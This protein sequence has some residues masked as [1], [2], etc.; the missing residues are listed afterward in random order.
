MGLTLLAAGCSSGPANSP[1][2]SSSHAVPAVHT[3]P[4]SFTQQ[5]LISG[6]DLTVQGALTTHG[7]LAGVHANGAVALRGQTSRVAG[8]LTSARQVEAPAG[9]ARKRQNNTPLA[10]ART[11]RP[12]LPTI[13]TLLQGGTPTGGTPTHA[14]L[15]GSDGAIQTSD[16]TGLLTP[17]DPTT[18]PGSWFFDAVTGC[19]HI[20]GGYLPLRQTLLVDG[21]LTLQTSHLDLHAALLVRGNATLIGAARIDVQN[22]FDPAVVVEG[23][24]ES[25]ALEVVGRMTIHGNVRATGD[26]YLTGSAQVGGDVTLLGSATVNYLDTVY[27]AALQRAQ[28]EFGDTLLVHSQVFR[29]VA[30][31]T[32]ANAVALMTFVRGYQE[33]DEE[34]LIAQIRAGTVQESDFFSVVVGADL[35]FG[36]ALAFTE[37]PAAYYYNKAGLLDHLANQGHFH[38]VVADALSLPPGNLYLTVQDESGDLGAFLVMGDPT[39]GTNTD[40]WVQLTQADVTAAQTAY[41]HRFA[42]L[43][44]QQAQAAAAGLLPPTLDEM[45]AADPYAA[46]D[47]PPDPGLTAG[48]L[49][50]QEWQA[51]ADLPEESATVEVVP[52]GVDPAAPLAARQEM[53]ARF[54]LGGFVSSLRSSVMGIVKIRIPPCRSWRDVTQLPGVNRQSQNDDWMRLISLKNAAR[55]GQNINNCGPVAGLAVLRYHGWRKPALRAS[56]MPTSTA[57]D[58]RNINF[59]DS[60]LHAD[61]VSMR[62]HMGT[63][64]VLTQGTLPWKMSDG[65]EAYLRD[66]GLGGR[67]GSTSYFGVGFSTNVGIP[68]PFYTPLLSE[69]GSASLFAKAVAEINQARPPILMDVG[70][71][72]RYKNHYMPVLGSKR[73]HFDGL[74]FWIPDE[75]YLYVDTEWDDKKQWQRIDQIAYPFN[76]FGLVTVNV[77]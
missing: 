12:E 7:V 22:P 57:N 64:A 8:S 51:I 14:I 20:S 34:G 61:L 11:L 15:L 32:G 30:K 1:P 38:P 29:D 5:A 62:G 50:L 36:A 44:E 52:Y 43:A 24:L 77:N 68:I 74:C 6:G 49:R 27:K 41:E 10:A 33:I 9:A 28:E 16:A 60:V 21:D 76:S 19:W 40:G 4:A 25:G 73:R 65:I 47:T 13:D 26:L 69:I 35:D 59:S 66:K 18:L 71:A 56:L 45:L 48:E 63:D 17:T 46:A 58:R 55:K 70:L 23:N 54:S 31:T 67:G 2:P 75:H 42:A 53:L 72:G 37:G 39:L 3:T